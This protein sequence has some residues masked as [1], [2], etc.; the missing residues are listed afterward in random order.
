MKVKRIDRVYVISFL[1][2]IKS[3]AFYFVVVHRDDAHQLSHRS[4]KPYPAS[5]HWRNTQWDENPVGLGNRT[6]N[7]TQSLVQILHCLYPPNMTK[8]GIELES[9]LK[10]PSPP[11][12]GPQVRGHVNLDFMVVTIITYISR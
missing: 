5:C 4:T 9:P 12:T 10:N 3:K 2:T 7:L 11:T 8:V 1:L 6:D